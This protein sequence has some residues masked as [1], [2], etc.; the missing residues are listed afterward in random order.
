MWSYLC[1][2]VEKKEK[3]K[4]VNQILVQYWY[5]ILIS[6]LIPYLLGWYQ[7]FT[8]LF[9]FCNFYASYFCYKDANRHLKN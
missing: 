8:Y 4:R 1:A 6:I 2:Y 5:K 9:I 7:Y 3:E